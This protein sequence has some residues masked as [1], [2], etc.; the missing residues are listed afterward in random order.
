MIRELDTVALAVDMPEHGL[1][2]GDIGAVVSVHGENAG[3]EVEFTT[4]DGET[5][6]VASLH[7]SQIRSIG[8]REMPH[9]RVLTA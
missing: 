5:I 3:F 7:P 6:T 8:P 1:K 9:A 2:A 4:L